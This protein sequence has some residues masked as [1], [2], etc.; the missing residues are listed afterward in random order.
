MI[1]KIDDWSTPESW[2]RKTCIILI[3]ADHLNKEIMVAVQFSMKSVM[4]IWH[5]LGNCDGDYEAV[6]RRKKHSGRSYFVR[7]AEFLEN[8]QTK[9]WKT[10]SSKLGLCHV[11]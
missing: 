5:E 10:Q 3:H 8:L 4:T 7:T 9:S 6:V 2:K 1:E 11:N